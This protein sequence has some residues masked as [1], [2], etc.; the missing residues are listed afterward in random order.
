MRA[1]DSCFDFPRVILGAK[2]Y[3]NRWR[4]CDQE[5]AW[6]PESQHLFGANF[7]ESLRWTE[8]GLHCKNGEIP[9]RAAD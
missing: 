2:G 9:A 4:L 8:V 5:Q 6:I 7:P 1:S 3:V